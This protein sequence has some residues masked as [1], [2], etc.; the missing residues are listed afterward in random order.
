[1]PGVAF[2]NRAVA[3]SGPAWDIGWSVAWNTASPFVLIP[4]PPGAM[5]WC[6]G[7][8]GT[9]VKTGSIPNGVFDSPGKTVVPA[10][11]YLHQLHDRLGD[12]AVRDT[13]Y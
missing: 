1:M 11:L 2:S 7:C 12:N 8:V 10:S 5:N 3:G 4:Q 13:G 6:I 9:P